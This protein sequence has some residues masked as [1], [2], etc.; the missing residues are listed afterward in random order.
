MTQKV[1]HSL[2]LAH[3]FAEFCEQVRNGIH[4]QIKNLSAAQ[5]RYESLAK[6]GGRSVLRFDAQLL[7]ADELQHEDDQDHSGPAIEFLNDLDEEKWLQNGMMVDASHEVLLLTRVLGSDDLPLE[8]LTYEVDSFVRRIVSLFEEGAVITASTFTAFVIDCMKSVRLIRIK[9]S[10]TKS[11]GG[12]HAPTHVV[13]QRCLNRM[14]SWGRLAI[15]II[16]TEFPSY[17][18]FRSFAVFSLSKE[19]KRGTHGEQ[20]KQ[21]DENVERLAQRFKLEQSTLT[22]EIN[23]YKKLATTIYRTSSSSTFEAWAKALQQRRRSHLVLKAH[24]QRAVAKV[25]MRLPLYAPTS[26]GVEQSHSRIAL[27]ITNNR[28]HM[29]EFSE[30]VAL[31][32]MLDRRAEEEQEI[33][34]R[35]RELYRELYGEARSQ[36]Q[37]R[38]DKG[39]Q[40]DSKATATGTEKAWLD[41]RRKSIDE[42][43]AKGSSME[44]APESCADA[45]TEK[46]DKEM[47][48]QVQKARG[49]KIEAFHDL[50]LISDDIDPTL[51]D[52]A[53]KERAKEAANAQKRQNKK[54]SKKAAMDTE[55]PT[56]DQMRG[57]AF[58]IE[59]GAHSA[60]LE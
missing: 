6:P 20:L 23:D 8:D 24:P 41:A 53:A 39:L 54:N 50:T 11:L 34:Q 49:L 5:H 25:V 45:W 26:S 40:K 27:V 13:K 4:T 29:H 21:D 15:Q 17:E 46:H 22:A 33:V 16:K 3:R 59:K 14:R 9:G 36:R 60:E 58:Y 37:A 12:P 44:I 47:A 32:L 19:S 18:I 10:K 28:R 2:A 51:P 38:S 42:A 48:F 43:A 56:L 1:Q 55:L 52:D 30:I 35:A 7:L 57:K 31:K